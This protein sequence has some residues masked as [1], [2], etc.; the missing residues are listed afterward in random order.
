MICKIRSDEYRNQIESTSIRTDQTS[1]KHHI[2]SY[3]VDLLIELP[4]F[5]K[6]RIFWLSIDDRCLVIF[7]DFLAIPLRP[8]L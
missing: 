6:W 1:K 7:L 4:A 2:Y 8:L 3:Y 5:N